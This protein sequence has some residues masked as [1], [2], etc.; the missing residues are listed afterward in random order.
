[1][2]FD[3]EDH[4]VDMYY[5]FKNSTWRNEILLEY[6]GFMGQEWENMARFVKN[7]GY[8]WKLAATKSL[9]SSHL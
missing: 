9:R 3:Q 4:Q 6:L 5:F 2:D 8:P 7:D 1:M